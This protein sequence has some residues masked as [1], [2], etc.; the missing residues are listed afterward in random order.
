M[1]YVV[2]FGILCYALLLYKTWQILFNVHSPQRK[3]G[4]RASKY[5]ANSL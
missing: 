1:E 3:Q 4:R 5:E 2:G